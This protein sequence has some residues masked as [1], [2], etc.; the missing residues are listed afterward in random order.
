[1]F[2]KHG[3]VGSADFPKSRWEAVE[4]PWVRCHFQQRNHSM[5]PQKPHAKW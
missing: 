2:P 1:M 5:D 3:T 4:K